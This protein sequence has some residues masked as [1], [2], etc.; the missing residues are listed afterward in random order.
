M[1]S[2]AKLYSVSVFY[3]LANVIIT[4]VNSVLLNRCLGVALRGEYTTIITVASLFQLVLN[5]G[6]GSS[7]PSFKRDKPIIAKEIIFTTTILLF[8]LYV[9]IFSIYIIYGS[10]EETYIGAITI[11][12]VLESILV[13]LA[14][15]ENVKKRNLIN[16]WTSV[17]NTL[18]L[19]IIFLFY[20]KNISLVLISVIANHL[21][22]SLLIIKIFNFKLCPLSLLR[23][24]FLASIFRV[25]LPAMLM[26]VLIYFNYHADVIFLSFLQKSQT[27][28]GIYGTAVTLGNMLWII[29]DAFK[30]II[31]Y[32][33]SIKEDAKEIVCSIIINFIICA[34]IIVAFLLLG[35]WF[36]T[37]L[38]GDDFAGA[39]PITL[40]IF[41]GTFPMILYKLIHPL[42][43][44]RGELKP[45]VLLLLL[46]VI[47][48]SILN[49]IFIP[50]YGGMG[51][52]VATVFSYSV[53]GI[54]FFIIFKKETKV[55]VTDSIKSM[56]DYML[57][58]WISRQK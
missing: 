21:L 32:R 23:R 15:I 9:F 54:S 47:I 28:V 27:V 41:I 22:L 18:V 40:V 3:K 12:S 42:Y 50:S 35:K 5:L 51:A 26:N 30:D 36:I 10:F 49:I 34:I 45:I 20:K 1:E 6:I 57:K 16:I 4:F 43:I 19:L 24:E 46:S 2:T 48:N 7:Y 25:S 29:P 52:A 33:V 44:A 39:Y 13:S 8:F 56:F 37:T 58:L 14:V 17:T 11:A 53:C 31:L 55:R 38:Y